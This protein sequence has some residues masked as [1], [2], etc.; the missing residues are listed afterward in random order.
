MLEECFKK[1]DEVL[2][3]M[4]KEDIDELEKCFNAGEYK[5]ILTLVESILEAFLIDWLL[6]RMV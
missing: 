4:L 2:K 5:A 6:E 3:Q 1:D